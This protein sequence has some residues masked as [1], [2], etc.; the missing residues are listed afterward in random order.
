MKKIYKKFIILV[1]LASTLLIASPSPAHA[2]SWGANLEATVYQITV[3]KM[4]KQIEDTIIANLKI[5]AIRII[6]G[7]L[8]VLLTGSPGK[9][10]GY[11]SSIITNWQ[12]FIFGSAQRYASAATNDF[13]RELRTGIPN[14]LQKRI[15]TPAEK[16]VE[17]SI[18]DTKPDAHYYV[19]NGDATKI[20]DSN[21][22]WW[23]WR[24]MAMPQNDLATWLLCAES[25]KQAAY[26]AMVIQK[27]VEGQ[28]GQGHIS[29]EKSKSDKPD[30]QNISVPGSTLKSLTDEILQLPLKMIEYAKSIPEVVTSMVTS[31]I[32]QLIQSGVTKLTEPIDQQI[33]NARSK[34][35]GTLNQ[36]QSAVQSGLTSK[37]YFSR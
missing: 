14:T 2:D 18:C 28:A 31:M 22:P 9:Y 16:A 12:N 21:N 34:Y 1:L 36:M 11:S 17:K 30:K 32:T 19:S 8:Q 27:S 23:R 20:F 26:Q 6:N 5:A 33:I 4:L 13:F 37:S 15:I 35:F 7:R 25:R 3:E 29:L 24:R 10:G